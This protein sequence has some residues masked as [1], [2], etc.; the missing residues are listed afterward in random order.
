M[1]TPADNSAGASSV[2]RCGETRA[3]VVTPES[4]ISLIRA[5]IRSG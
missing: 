4:L 2:V 1:S 5:M 3:A